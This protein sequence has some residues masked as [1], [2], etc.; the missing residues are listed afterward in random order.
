M[1]NMNPFKKRDTA[2]YFFYPMFHPSKNML[3]ND[4]I[5][6][7]CDSLQLKPE[8]TIPTA[9]Y[10]HIPFCDSFCH[11]CACYKTRTPKDKDVFK[12]YTDS[13]KSE[14]NF[15]SSTPYVQ[16]LEIDFVYFGGGTPST[17]TPELIEDLISFIKE[18]FRLTKDVVINFEG[19]VR[20]LSDD[21]RLKALKNSGCNRISFGVQTFNSTSRKQTGLVPRKEDITK[22]I[23]KLRDFGYK[24]N[25]DLMFGL[26]GQDIEVWK[27]DLK[28]AVE[29]GADG[30]DLYE[31]VVYPTT[32]LFQFRHNLIFAKDHE[33]TE[34][35]NYAI[36]YLKENDFIQR[37]KAIFQKK[38]NILKRA[39]V[40]YHASGDNVISIGDSAIGYLNNFAYRNR[41]PLNEY[42]NWNKEDSSQLPLRL[43]FELSRREILTRNITHLPKCL[44]IEKK[45]FSK[46]I[47]YFKEPLNLLKEK[48]LIEENSKE[49]KLTELGLLWTDNIISELVSHQE[50]KRAWKIMY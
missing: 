37:T 14:I 44:R 21:D 50:Q 25:F 13:L 18:K 3:S 47:K 27:Q 33:R 36:N 45:N 10:V 16:S 39:E 8:T 42:I 48:E 49:I 46:E 11:M 41:S 15:Y 23:K 32:K 31:T 40:M 30:L 12:K 1:E 17:L 35:L 22:C 2:P 6:K 5:N 7:F 38:D 19:D 4:D 9:L 20:T 26:P 34:M 28:T 29:V 24:I 43:G